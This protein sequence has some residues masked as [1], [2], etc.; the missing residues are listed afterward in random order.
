M[1]IKKEIKEQE[2]SSNPDT[3]KKEPNKEQEE[4]KE[5]SFQEQEQLR[6]DTR[7]KKWDENYNNTELLKESKKLE[8]GHYSRGNYLPW[9]VAY[10]EFIRQGGRVLQWHIDRMEL[11]YDDGAL[12][13]L[14]DK[15]CKKYYVY[16]VHI[17]ASWM[18]DIQHITYPMLDNVGK[19]LV[20]GVKSAKLQERSLTATKPDTNTKPIVQLQGITGDMITKN[21]QRALTKLIALISGIGY[22]LYDNNDDL[23]GDDDE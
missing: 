4:K 7:L 15:D 13:G 19:G 2:K 10:R 23:W 8:L 22:K 17:S 1:E 5:L 6:I 20:N 12:L 9:G 16:Y 3:K 18:G 14:D 11:E 21:Y